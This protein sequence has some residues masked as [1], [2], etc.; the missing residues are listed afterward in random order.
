MQNSQLLLGLNLVL[1]ILECTPG[2]ELLLSQSHH[3]VFSKHHTIC[4]LT[5]GAG[6][7]CIYT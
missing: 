2:I 6:A 1:Q 3:S 4:I 5:T 7:E